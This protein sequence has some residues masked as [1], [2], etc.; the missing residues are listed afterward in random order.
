MHTRVLGFTFLVFALGT[1]LVVAQVSDQTRQ[2]RREFI[3]GLLKTLIDS[4]D[5]DHGDHG[6]FQPRPN[7]PVNPGIPLAGTRSLQEMR[8]GL[9]QFAIQADELVRDLQKAQ[10]ESPQARALL[11]DA[12]QIR[13]QTSAL[14]RYANRV[15][16][17]REIIAD[18]QALDQ[19]WRVL[20]HRIRQT[21]GIDAHCLGLVD[22]L[23]SYGD[24]MCT[25]LGVEPTLNRAELVRLTSAMRLSFQHLLQDIFYDHRNN[26]KVPRILD[27]GNELFAK[28]NQ[29]AALIE[30]EPYDS[31]VASYEDIVKSWKHYT[32]KLRP[33][34]TERIRRDI[35]EIESLGRAI[36]EQL[37]LPVQLDTD[38]V[39]DVVQGIESD[40]AK[41]YA[42]I[43]LEDLLQC[44][45]PGTV[46]NTAREF[47]RRCGALS[48]SLQGGLESWMWDY[49]LFN[50]QWY[51]LLNQCQSIQ[52]PRVARRL[53]EIDDAM[54]SL[55]QVMGQG[56]AITR[57]DLIQLTG[58]LDQIATDI[59]RAVNEH[60]V[61]DRNYDRRFRSE[62]DDRS[63][64]L[65]D[66]V[67]DCHQALIVGRRQQD[68]NQELR[69]IFDHW[70]AFKQLANQCNDQ[71]RQS[72]HGFRRSMEPLMVKLQV[73]FSS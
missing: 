60:V 72:F 27:E 10:F 33:L 9:S 24:Q 31:I 14:I 38:Y 62:I 36:H 11:A 37:W 42:S 50:V 57:D 63:R 47:R 67:H 41:L 23:Q 48:T 3:G 22:Q 4:Q 59:Q 55:T 20:A 28:I 7:Q 39:I 73:I 58:Q 32:R 35:E 70:T 2:K 29:A 13:A 69:I 56:P 6:G 68:L 52:H 43:T 34:Q 45:N 18:Y 30:R 65:H 21:P 15:S 51:A 64:R 66:A 17:H 46:L 19:N 54:I 71:H 5:H 1:Q 44:E 8:Q 40:V 25:C 26:P 12:M 16:D 53:R 61:R 49:Q